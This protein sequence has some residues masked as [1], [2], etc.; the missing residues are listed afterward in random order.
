MLL[1]PTGII[2]KR[3]ISILNLYEDIHY[4]FVS[5]S[6]NYYKFKYSNCS[7]IAYKNTYSEASTFDSFRQS[8]H[9]AGFNFPSPSLSAASNT[10]RSSSNC[11]S[12][13]LVIKKNAILYLEL[14]T[15]NIIVLEMF[16]YKSRYVLNVII[17]TSRCVQTP[18]F[19][20]Y[21]KINSSKELSKLSSTNHLIYVTEC[22][23]LCSFFCA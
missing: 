17:C 15:L 22:Y 14:I 19:Y 13:L 7:V 6:F 9:S 12:F 16:I 23:Y 20:R 8:I 3:V 11:L 5:S 21:M 2:I 10:F 4:Q 18:S 1:S